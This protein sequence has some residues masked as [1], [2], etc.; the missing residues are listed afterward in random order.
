MTELAEEVFGDDE[1]TDEDLALA[2]GGTNWDAEDIGTLV[3]TS[4]FGTLVIASTLGG[5]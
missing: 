2:A 1:L 4:A 5:I 3:G